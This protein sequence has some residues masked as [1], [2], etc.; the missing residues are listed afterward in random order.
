M[1]SVVL[2]LHLREVNSSTMIATLGHCQFVCVQISGKSA[3]IQH[4]LGK[5]AAFFKT[6]HCWTLL[7]KY[8]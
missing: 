7:I 3:V 4:C 2:W 1:Y 6:T 8:T 5:S